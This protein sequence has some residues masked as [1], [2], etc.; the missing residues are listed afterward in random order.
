MAELNRIQK[1]KL[2]RLFEMESGYVLDFSN[3][4]FHE[5]IY[6]CMKVDIEDKKYANWGS[7]KAKRLRAFWRIESP[8]RVSKL[9]LALIEYKKEIDSVR[10]SFD[11]DFETDDN[12]IH[13]CIII[14]QS[15]ISEDVTENI[16]ELENLAKDEEDVKKLLKSIRESIE[17]NEP[18]M[19][20]DRLHTFC[21]KYIRGLCNKYNIKYDENKPLHSCFGEYVKFLKNNK[22]IET[23]MTYTI[24]R[25]SISIFNDYNF[26]RNR[27]SYAHDNDILNYEESLLIYRSV[28]SILSFIESYEAKSNQSSSNSLENVE[29]L[30]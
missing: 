14:A 29:S 27:K 21:V 12:L 7:S 28:T 19:A 5:F 22:L 10:K 16:I 4:T 6:D 24:L 23:D 30:F 26:V 13:E 11:E 1:M 9:I 25:N 8:Y 15:L 20:L 17:N 18:E 3:R 2:E